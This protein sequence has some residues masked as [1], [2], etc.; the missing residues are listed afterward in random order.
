MQ[1]AALAEV[2]RAA[3]SAAAR[4]WS[5]E[6]IALNMRLSVAHVRQEIVCQPDFPLPVPKS[7]QPRWVATAV[8][9]WYEGRA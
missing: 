8:Q 2:V 3:Q 9:A 4:W 1:A 7:K 6:D 5:T